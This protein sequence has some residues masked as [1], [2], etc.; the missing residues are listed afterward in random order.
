M[1]NNLHINLLRQG[2][3]VWNLWREENPLSIPNLKGANLVEASLQGANLVEANLV[4]ANLDR[5]SLD[6]E[7]KAYCRSRGALVN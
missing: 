2:F 4:E 6:D 1:A 3:K 5:A 7:L